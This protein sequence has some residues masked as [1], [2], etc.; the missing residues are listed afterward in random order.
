VPD[1]TSRNVATQNEAPWSLLNVYKQLF[2]LRHTYRAIKDGKT[3]LRDSSK[4]VLVYSR[5]TDAEHVLIA[6][7]LG[8][9]TEIYDTGKSMPTVLLSTVLG[10]EIKEGKLVLKPYSGLV[11]K[12]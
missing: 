10:Q 11:V 12:L 6:I 8:P 4:N 3:T 2:Q 9:Q 1:Y 7:N 5:E